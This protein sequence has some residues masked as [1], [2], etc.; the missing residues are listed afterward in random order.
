VEPD[1]KRRLDDV[2]L[3]ARVEADA[4]RMRAEEFDRLIA[5]P[6][7]RA[8]ALLRRLPATVASRAWS[9]RPSACDGARSLPH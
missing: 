1:V 3:R 8:L 4:R 9:P 6:V 2:E 7:A 5:I